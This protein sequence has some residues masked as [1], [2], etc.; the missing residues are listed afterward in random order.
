MDLV[1]CNGKTGQI[2]FSIMCDGAVQ[3]CN[4]DWACGWS[5]VDDASGHDAE[6]GGAAAVGDSKRVRGNDRREVLQ[7]QE[8][9]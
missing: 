6:E 1:C 4:T 8:I 7:A 9:N 5:F 2:K 3:T